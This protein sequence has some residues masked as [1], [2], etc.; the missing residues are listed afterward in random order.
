MRRARFIPLLLIPLLVLA[1]GGCRRGK[2]KQQAAQP[3]KALPNRLVHVLC[4]HALSD[5][6]KADTQLTP[7]DFT[8][9]MQVLKQGGYQAISCRQ[10]ADYLADAQDIPDKS[11]IIS[12]DDG[13]KSVLTKAKPI[14]D[15]FGFKPVLFVNPVSVG[16]KSYLSWDNLKTLMQA[17]YEIDSHTVTHPNLTQKAKSQTLKQVQ[18][19]A[20]EEI[21]QSYRDIEE[22]VGQAPVALAYPFGNYDQY[23]MQV[24]RDTGYRLGLSIDPGAVDHQSDPWTLPRKMIVNGTSLKTFQRFLETEPLHLTNVQPALGV[25]LPSRQYKFTAQLLDEDAAATLQAETKNGAK[26][27]Y[28][29]ASR[30]LTITAHLDRGANAMRLLSSGKPRRDLGWIVVVDVQD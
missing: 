29:P 7:Q 16:G 21:E 9:Q 4:Y 6:P 12:F 5:R 24:T 20:R 13:W 17:G 26:L 11:V 14:L 23:V 8:A 1:A 15:Q 18:E 25:R 28:D 30:M 19:K 22:H 27:K 3:P 10:L 2:P